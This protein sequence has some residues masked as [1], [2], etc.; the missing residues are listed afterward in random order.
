[1]DPVS[2][3]LLIQEVK[4]VFDGEGQSASTMDCAEQRLKEVVDKFL[5]CSLENQ[6]TEVQEMDFNQRQRTLAMKLQHGET[7]KHLSS[8][9]PGQINLRHHLTTPVAFLL[10]SMFVVLHKMPHLHPTFEI[11]RD[12][13]CTWT[14]AVGAARIAERGICQRRKGRNYMKVCNDL[15]WKQHRHKMSWCS[16]ISPV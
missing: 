5:Q 14:E 1:M 6:D 4:H 3:R 9:Q 11:R 13:G 7:L 16:N 8:Q 10:I 12:H 15:S 2:V